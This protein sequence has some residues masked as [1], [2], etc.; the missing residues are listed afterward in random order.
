MEGPVFLAEGVV[1]FGEDSVGG[2]KQREGVSFVF[3]GEGCFDPEWF[4]FNWEV[5]FHDDDCI[6]VIVVIGFVFL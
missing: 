2:E 6:F 5:V 3:C 4:D 1:V